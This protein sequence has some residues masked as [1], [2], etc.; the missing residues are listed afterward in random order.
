MFSQVVIF[1]CMGAAFIRGVSVCV[2]VFAVFD[3]FG[4]IVCRCVFVACVCVLWVFI[5]S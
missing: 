2:R 5:C 4:V 1:W 3:V